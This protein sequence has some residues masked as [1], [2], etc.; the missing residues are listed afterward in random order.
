[1]SSS[2]DSSTRR[3]RVMTS[4]LLRGRAEDSPHGRR[5]RVPFADFDLELLPALRRQ[6]IEL[7]AP[8]VLGGAVIERNPATFDQPVKGWIE[9]ALLDQE[10]VIRATFDRFRERMS[11]RGSPSQ[12]AQ[13]QE[14]ECALQEFDAAL[15]ASSRHSRWRRYTA[16][17]RTSRCATGLRGLE[18]LV[19]A[20]DLGNGEC[21]LGRANWTP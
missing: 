17:P 10:H 7:G 5:Q 15:V 2:S 21:G 3:P 19:E 12:R 16:S 14:V 1:M 8:I 9:G 6:S 11:V 20:V 18:G 4:F 13:N